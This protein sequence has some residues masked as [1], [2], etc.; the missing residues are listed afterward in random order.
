MRSKQ[1]IQLKYCK[2][3]FALIAYFEAMVNLIVLIFTQ[4]NRVKHLMDT[5]AA[6]RSEER[7][8]GWQFSTMVTLHL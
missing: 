8:H 7:Y 3:K 2:H 1:K 5:E 6:Q 4:R